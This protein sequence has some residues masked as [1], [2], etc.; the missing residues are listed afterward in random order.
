MTAS[1]PVLTIAVSSSGVTA[2]CRP[3]ISLAPPTPPASAA[4]LTE[5][6]CSAAPRG[7]LGRTARRARGGLGRTARRARGGLGRTARGG[8]GGVGR[9]RGRGRGGGPGGPPKGGGG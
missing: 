2:R 9:G 7:G 6:Q 5:P 8:R 3:T 4:T 1:S